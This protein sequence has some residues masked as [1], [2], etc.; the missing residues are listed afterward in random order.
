MRD[1]ARISVS[2]LF[3]LMSC[4][5]AQGADAAFGL[6]ACHARERSGHDEALSG[7]CISIPMS[8]G[9]SSLNLATAVAVV[10]YGWKLG[11]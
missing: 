4:L 5:A 6:V 1:T 7:H 8:D 9:V 3:M 11:Q 2:A 10:L